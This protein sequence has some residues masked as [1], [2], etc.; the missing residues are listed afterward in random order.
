MNYLYEPSK[1]FLTYGSIISFMFDKDDKTLAQ[2]LLDFPDDQNV[3]KSQINSLNLRK[4]EF[5][6]IL[7][8]REFLYSQGVFNEF[9]FFHN[10]KDKTELKYNYYNTLFLVLPK[11]EY[12]SMS[13]LRALKKKLK[14]EIL[15]DDDLDIDRQQIINSYSKFK[16]EIFSNQEFA[17]KILNS[18]DKFVN[19]NDSV[20]FMHIKSGKF[21]EYKKNSESFKI[22]IQLTD[23]LSENTIFHFIPAFNY[24]GENSA[25]VMI[26][27]ILKIACGEK[28]FSQENEKFLSKR[29]NISKSVIPNL[30]SNITEKNIPPRSRALSLGK[31][32]LFK[33]M[34][35]V[36]DVKYKAFKKIKESRTSIRNIVNDE[37]THEKIK[38]NFRT[39]IN[40][41]DIAFN[42]F[43]KKILPN[44]EETIIAKN[45]TSNFWRI[46]NFSTN[47][48]EDNKYINS[49]D[50]FCIQNN[51]KNLY[52]QS[53]FS[54]IDRRRYRY[55]SEIN[56]T[57]E[58]NFFEIIDNQS[59]NIEGRKKQTISIDTSQY[60]KETNTT[61]DNEIKLNYFYDKE[62][63]IESNYE[64]I[65]NSFEENDYIEPLSLF[66]FEVVYN[67]GNYGI[68]E[69][70]PKYT[71]D[72]L[73]DNSF[74]RLINVFTNKVLIA[75]LIETRLGKIYRLRLVNNQ[76]ISRRDYFKSVFII[77]KIQD[78][79]EILNE[80]AIENKNEKNKN[81]K[82]E[83][84]I[85]INKN[86]YIKIKSKK[87][88]IYLGI[89]L[90]NELNSRSLVLT[91]S[92]S[93]LTRFK[94]NFLDEIDKYELH[95]FEQLISSFTN[96]INYFKLEEKN[97]SDNNITF[98]NYTNYEK[99]QHILIELEKRIN[100]FP[101]NNKVNISQKNKFD[102]MKAI[103]HFAVVSKLVDIFLA[104]WF[105]D[106]NNLNYYDMEKKLEKY[107]EESVEGDL[108]LTKYKQLI[109]KK[110]FKILN[111]IYD[112]NKSYLNVIEDKLL[113]FFMFVGR[114]DKCTKFLIHILNNN[115]PLLI[116]LCPIYIN[117]I[118]DAS[119][120]ENNYSNNPNHYNITNNKYTQNQYNINNINRQIN[121]IN[122]YRSKGENQ[123]KYI[124][125]KHCLSRIIQSYNSLDIVQLK[126][127]FSSVL[128]LFKMFNCLLIYN[129]K[130][131]NQFYDEYFKDLELIKTVNGETSPYY[132]KNPILVEFVLKDNYK[133]F[134][135]KKKFFVT[136]RKKKSFL[137]DII[138]KVEN[139][140]E[141][142]EE[143]YEGLT[144]TSLNDDEFE[145]DLLELIDI[146]MKKDVINNYSAIILSK[147]VSLN[148]IFY[149]HLSLCNKNLNLYL[150]HIF[151]FDNIINNYLIDKNNI[152]NINLTSSFITNNEKKT[153]YNI[154]N[155]LKCSLTHLL[156]YLY[157]HISFPFMGKMDLFYCLEPEIVRNNS[158]NLHMSIIHNI[159]LKE[160]DEDLL[161]KIVDY[162]SKLLKESTNPDL[163]NNIE[164]FFF[165]QI[166]EC[167][168]YILRNLYTYKNNEE[169]TDKSIYLISL[170]LLLLEEFLG[171]SLTKEIIGT[172]K[173]IVYSLNMIKNDS[174]D[175]NDSLYLISDNSKLIFEKKRKKLE[176][177]IK[178]KEIISKKKLFKEL[179][180]IFI[181]QKEEKKYFLDYENNKYRQR[182]LDKLR[183][184]ELSQILMEISISRNN[185]HK[186]I[187]D[188]ILFLITD[189]LLEFLQYIENLEIDKVY[190][191]IEELNRLQI[192]QKPR[193]TEEEFYDNLILSIV[194]NKENVNRNTNIYLEKVIKEYLKQKQKENTDQGQEINSISSFFFK[195]LQLIDNEELKK[196]NLEI[197]YKSNSQRKIF[198]ENITNIVLLDN[199]LIYNKFLKIKELFIK[200]FNTMHSLSLIKILDNNS[201]TLFEVLNVNFEHL[202]NSLLDEKQWRK[203]N[204]IFNVY[205]K[206]NYNEEEN[207]NKSSKLVRKKSIF[208][209][210]LS[211]DQ[212]IFPYQY[213]LS[214]FSKEKVSIT[215][216]TL[217]NLG[218]I[219]L[220]NQIFE[221]IS[222]VVN[223]KDDFND[224]LLALEKILISI[225]KLLVLFIFDNKKHQFLIKEK[226]NLYLCPLKLKN[227]SQDIL[228]FIGYFLLNVVYFF[229]TQDDFN[230]IK[231]L[232]NVIS[233]LNILQY[234]E[235]GKN[236]QIIPFY[237]QSF[238][239]IISF[240]N[241][242]YFVLLYPVLEVINKV[243]VNEIRKNTDTNDDLLSLIKILDLIIIE[244]N[245]K[246]NDNKNTS[247]L[248]LKDIID[249]FLSMIN[250]ITQ[251]TIK[252]YMKLS[253]I[254]VLVTNLLYKHYDLYKNDFLINK[255]Y[256]KT[257]TEILISFNERF[258][259]TDDLVYC[260]K[261]K[262]NLNL[263][264]FNEFIGISIPKL[265]I[266]LS[267][268]Q[269]TK[270]TK[271]DSFSKII[272]LPNEL[273]SKILERLES[274]KK[275]KI[276]LTKKNEA[277]VDEI[278]KKIGID[279]A[280]LSIIK[281]N[282]ITSKLK[283]S[284]P[285]LIKSLKTRQNLLNKLLAN[286]E[287]SPESF[288]F[289]WNKIKTR[290]NYK[291]G[292]YNF[293]NYAKYEINKE[294]MDY[295]QTLDNFFNEISENNNN[296]NEDISD[297]SVVFFNNYIDILKDYYAKDFIN[298]KNEI[299]FFY[300]TNIHLMRYNRKKKYFLDNEKTL[301]DILKVRE[302]ENV[303]IN[304]VNTLINNNMYYN[305][306]A[307]NLNNIITNVDNNNI[308]ESNIAPIDSKDKDKDETSDIPKK[309]LN[310]CEEESKNYFN[311]IL[312]PYN[313]I[314]FN[315]LNFIE[316]T[317]KQFSHVKIYSNDYE[318]LLYIKFLNSYLD[319]L[320]EENLSKFL[321]FFIK[322]PE[323]ENIF[324]LMNDILETLNNEIIRVLT[325]EEEINFKG[326]DKTTVEKTK[327]IANIFENDFDKYEL[328]IDFITKLSANNI[329]IQ[330]KMKDYLRIQYNNSRSYNF[331]SMLSNILVNFTKENSRLVFIDK[332]Y[333]LIIQIINC[334]TK[335]CNGPSKDNQDCVVIE[336]DLLS[337]ARHILKNITYRQKKFNDSGFDLKQSYDR[338][339]IDDISENLVDK[340]NEDYLYE[341]RYDNDILID[342]CLNIGLNRKKL[343]YMKLRILILISVL[344]LGRKKE[345][346]LF[347]I[348]H[349][350]IDFDVLVCVIIET[351][352]EILIEKDSQL[353][354]ENLIFDE[355]MLLRMNKDIYSPENCDENFI[356][357]EIGTYTFILINL[358]MNH[359]TRP[360]DFNIQNK[361]SSF[362]KEL[363]RKKYIRKKSSIF[364]S[365]K[366]YGHSI[367]RCFRELCI[368]CGNCLTKNV[369]EDFYLPKS[370]FCAYSFYFDYTQNIEILDNNNLIKY[371]VKLSPICKCLT[372]E[373]KEE[374]YSKL[375]GSS[376]NAKIEAIFK[377][378]DYYHYQFIHAKRRLD[379]FRKMPFLDLLLNHYKFYEDVFMIIG[380]LLNIL[381]FASLYR[382]NDDYTK[383]EK[384]SSD[385]KYDYGFLYKHKNIT[386]TR[387]IF[388]SMTFIECI[389]AFLIL[390]TYI[391]N[392]WSNYF[393]YEISDSEKEEFYKNE[394]EINY[395]YSENKDIFSLDDYEKMRKNIKIFPR[396]F[397]FLV[398][399]IKD[400]KLFYHLIILADC[401]IALI[402]QNYR[403]LVL[404]LVEIII[405]SDTLIY[406]VKSFW[407]P[408]KQLITT[409]ILFYLIAYYFIIF[410]YLFIPHH[411]PTRDCF[412][413]S[414]CFFT[415]CDQTIKNSNGIIN[416]LIEDGLYI[417]KT[418]YQNPRFWIDN[419]FAII[420][421][422]LVLQMVCG[423]ITDSYISQRKEK[424]KFLKNKNNICFI[425]GLGKP[426]LIKYYAHE[427]GFDEHIKLDHYLWNYMFLIFNVSKKSFGELINL[428][429]DI[430]DNYRKGSYS[431]FVPYKNCWKKI[432]AEEKNIIEESEDK[433]NKDDIKNNE[434]K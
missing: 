401:V 394:E 334:I 395:Y 203:E 155:D 392:R 13:K 162:V 183:K 115:G 153:N 7:I 232:D 299:Y 159:K 415:L 131:F 75:E 196:K 283:L 102:F 281:N 323:A 294:R 208:N 322:Q 31:E 416:Y 340:F 175:I 111:I 49:L 314:Y 391:T 351:Y 169:K 186:S 129:H 256:S 355:D 266:I 121:N 44:E 387:N 260:N 210:D 331:I 338:Y 413:F 267:Y 146:N 398:N 45:K 164:P 339:Y 397:S 67:V 123:D 406:I 230:Q 417:T 321:I 319:Y 379:L 126:I 326:F 144:N 213:F 235:W 262:N 396:V 32:I 254:F 4:D 78:Y 258:K 63:N 30:N 93:D 39:Y 301:L 212:N 33:A 246:C 47:F 189:I 223:I 138:N 377:N 279:I 180:L 382:T 361:I 80:D 277:E 380:A 410:V 145:F 219:N 278:L 90:N 292:L 369:H 142:E 333:K 184:Y 82:K 192:K 248:S 214:E 359:L 370:F 84:N 259:L 59:Q 371:Y 366:A 276:F 195:F 205:G 168:K 264:Y 56:L 187:R 38:N 85:Y 247:I 181:S 275:E 77:E 288:S 200:L 57:E 318:Y 384:Y 199:K 270:N 363:K 216:Q 297:N 9:C 152:E 100:N 26:N 426:E 50:F 107:F 220:I 83:K 188:D 251:N 125:F 225:Y 139:K 295:V 117:K 364:D 420:D 171:F 312:T 302:K 432:E 399:F 170:I 109:S 393:Y 11:G 315:D 332:Y 173:N 362:N 43:G 157:F 409:L 89:R 114:D 112:L 287:L 268:S 1:I 182:T 191:K 86:E 101:E 143:I 242:E 14:K 52:I 224:E 327:Y 176:K 20:Q 237:V 385:F 97:V 201:F 119:L 5:S 53:N 308:N 291:N 60:K 428:D 271:D 21:L 34:K 378:V 177:I 64:L 147:L 106:I 336:T 383:V 335:C 285:K 411:L 373:M 313:K 250:L 236:K 434:E 303:Y 284:V 376:T 337:F 154:S 357:F 148:L 136:N 28:Q 286:D 418:L 311:Y 202:I 374:F 329:I 282:I 310:P 367:Y 161:N 133:I 41:S 427:Q 425:C 239:I 348:I 99:I 156:N 421:L 141:I 46:L 65:V 35:K 132:E 365:T 215:Q 72:I 25:K 241:Y 194:K 228:L 231:N 68:Y 113:Y 18:K 381:L 54:S 320:D 407:L 122:T 135:K 253:Q 352:K 130:P 305:E 91:N 70:N 134:V 273:Y 316:L 73:Q 40:D 6:D 347:E 293:Q 165:C 207:N 345:D 19:F 226:L 372:E 150:R 120:M 209:S 272:N 2:I 51:E 388:F 404:L 429:K 243:L 8:S 185:E 375:V 257:L 137:M 353:H 424:N 400:A 218:F 414:D 160:I 261:N 309:D 48:I 304:P 265:Y 29:Q 42:D 431:N 263:R 23:T 402:S 249:V 71:I 151:D 69:E 298:Y 62:F 233:S 343:S 108:N 98:D 423:I 403:F 88:N 289:I 110:I 419:F 368:K 422:M 350:K 92:I 245:K 76:E 105:H 238:K 206:I 408:K 197:L 158:K 222:W 211:D 354:Y 74:V 255:R 81:K 166:L 296:K 244:Q 124:C 325:K 103:E 405:H 163:L 430:L 386:I 269:I 87:Y 252:K 178:T 96:I 27:L 317:L 79:E 58:E 36:D 179:F 22:H 204:N 167:T 349:N 174:L 127:N 15:V 17:I 346:Y 227:K 149:S 198:F 12:E 412:R 328:I 280:L 104:N 389:I 356:I 240:C 390:V 193:Q 61:H 140:V 217:Y 118:K 229:E 24:Q 172:N 234:L 128:L 300:W 307:N 344:T 330:S 324:S 306:S 37:K 433:K 95:F 16:Q 274:D 190:Q 116:S 342:E 221:Y 358:F 360:F 94:L 290:I 66:K 341:D 3:D 10:F 55:S